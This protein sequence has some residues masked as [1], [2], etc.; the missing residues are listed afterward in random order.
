MDDIRF[1]R[2]ALSLAEKGRGLVA[3]NPVVGCVIVKDETIVGR[4][5]HRIVDSSHIHTML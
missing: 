5:Y 1:M 4:G 3:P 2:E